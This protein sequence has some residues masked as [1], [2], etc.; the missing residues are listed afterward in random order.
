VREL[1]RRRF[2][3]PW[4]APRRAGWWLLIV[5]SAVGA[6]WVWQGLE[7]GW[8]DFPTVGLTALAL[9]VPLAVTWWWL[10]RI[11]QLWQRIAPSGALAAILWGAVVAAGVYALPSNSALITVMGQRVSIDAAQLW[12][13]A[14][15]APLTEETGK[16]MVVGV[17]LLAAGQKLRTPMDAALLAGFAGVG[18]TLTEDLLY[19]FNIAYLNLGENQVISTVV[20]Y[21]VRAVLFGAVSHAAFAAFVGAGIG[22]L[23]VGRARGRVPLGIAL[24]VLG[25]MLHG[26][27]NSPW[28]VS[29]WLRVLY[30]VVVPLIVWWVLRVVRRSEYLWFRQVLLEPGVLG[31]IPPAYLDAVRPTWWKRRQYRASVART[32]GHQAMPAQRATEANLTDLA[33]AACVGDDVDAS[34]LRATLEA[35]L[36]PVR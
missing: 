21:F 24:I 5:A 29:L 19:A 25:P 23:L 9:T 32:Y 35:R 10:M 15:I 33:D 18:F 6:V 27:W 12:G 8:R 14:L 20:I 28:L 36:V 2:A 11:P 7:P 31:A 34:R 1:T 13:P 30:L 3:V 22:F 26:L 16:V 4:W 17:V